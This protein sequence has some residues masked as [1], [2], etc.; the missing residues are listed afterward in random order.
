M[1]TRPSDR[2]GIS[3]TLEDHASAFAGSSAALTH[4]LESGLP[5]AREEATSADIASCPQPRWSS[6]SEAAHA[7]DRETSAGSQQDQPT[8][9][10]VGNELP[11]SRE[12]LRGFT[13]V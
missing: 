13:S 5:A 8:C 11:E 2:L 4:K 10:V 12:V 6:P 7:P 3:L 9:L 1:R